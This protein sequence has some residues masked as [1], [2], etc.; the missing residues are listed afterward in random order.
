MND[1]RIYTLF[2]GSGG[3]CHYIKCGDTHLLFDT[4]KNAKAVT[5]A[6]SSI[7]ADISDIQS[8]YI[9]HEHSD[10]TSALRV[11][12]KKNPHLSVVCHPL[13]SEAIERGGIDMTG[14]F[15]IY[16][17]ESKSEGC[18]RV[19]AFRVPHDSSACLGYRIDF[20]EGEDSRSIGIAT[21]IGNLTSD[22]A[23][24][25]CGCEFVI[26]EANHDPDML[27]TGPYP[28]SLKERIFSAGGHLSN[29]ACARLC[30][31]LYEHGA[32]YFTLAH[33]SKENNTPDL[34]LRTV[35]ESMG[36]GAHLVC[37]SQD[38]PVCLYET[39]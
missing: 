8:V 13:C 19:S 5:C 3:N 14:V 37:A 9:T 31:Y 28:A 11:L 38:S 36:E 22:I 39:E 27:R 34:A 17:G 4:G 26:I 16:G 32:R 33:I 10:H 1:I 6:L 20:G 12:K 2:S 25:L 29:E 7:G 15:Y 30:S 24:G 21:D 35:R 18:V 23:E